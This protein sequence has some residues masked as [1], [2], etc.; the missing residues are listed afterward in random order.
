MKRKIDHLDFETYKKFL[1]NAVNEG[2]EEVGLYSTGEP[3]MTKNL[4]K[5]IFEV[6]KNWY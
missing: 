1:K 6:K 3:F 5:F 4:D 2:L